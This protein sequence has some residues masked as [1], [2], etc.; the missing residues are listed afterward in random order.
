MVN[1]ANTRATRA[2]IETVD[3]DAKVL[4]NLLQHILDVTVQ[5]YETLGMPTP[6]RQYWTIGEAAIDCEQIV[7]SFTQMYVGLPGDEAVT[8][9]RCNDPRSATINIQVA[10]QFPSVSESGTAPSADVIQT[11]STLAAYDAWVLMEAVREMDSWVDEFGRPTA[12]GPGVIATVDA[13]TAE[14]GY[15]ATNLTLTIQVP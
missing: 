12:L 14:G 15:Q 4:A 6:A 9:R 10:R 3:D 13:A 2:I 5:V 11:Y 8:P 1:S 7:V